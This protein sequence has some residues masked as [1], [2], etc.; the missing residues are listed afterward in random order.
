VGH[1]AN[2]GASFGGL[3]TFWDSGFSALV[4][5]DLETLASESRVQ[6]GAWQRLQPYTINLLESSTDLSIKA[7]SL[8]LAASLDK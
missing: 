4:R 7:A 6:R 2:L 8:D 5:S 3:E 1:F